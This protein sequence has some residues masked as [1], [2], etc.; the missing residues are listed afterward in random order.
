ME[1]KKQARIESDWTHKLGIDELNE[2]GKKP[3]LLLFNKT[4]IGPGFDLKNDELVKK[5]IA[6]IE[7]RSSSYLVDRYNQHMAEHIRETERQIECLIKSLLNEPYRDLLLEKNPGLFEFLQTAKPDTF[8][9]LD[10]RPPDWRS[11]ESL[12]SLSALLK[13]LKKISKFFR[14]EII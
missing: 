4:D 6:A 9:E 1:I 12:K 2:I 7:V 8:K 5:A 13:Q 14:K 10:F 3:D 11:S